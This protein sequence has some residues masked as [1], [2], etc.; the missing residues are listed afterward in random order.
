MKKKSSIDR[1]H[2][3]LKRAPGEFE[4]L[5]ELVAAVIP[6][7]VRYGGD[8]DQETW[9]LEGKVAIWQWDD[10]WHVERCT[11]RGEWAITEGAVR[12]LTHGRCTPPLDFPP[13]RRVEVLRWLNDNPYPEEG[14]REWFARL[15]AV[16]LPEVP[17]VVCDDRG[18]FPRPAVPMN[19][20]LG[21]RVVPIDPREP[22]PKTATWRVVADLRIHRPDETRTVDRYGRRVEPTPEPTPDLVAPVAV[23]VEWA[24]P[25]RRGRRVYTPQDPREG[26][27]M[28]EPT[29]VRGA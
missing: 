27:P 14:A 26:W 1:A 15:Q 28:V 24:L 20:I 4:S 6:E 16:A 7:C 29:E 17:R 5:A 10:L 11:S 8:G 23:L 9:V 18:Y 3:L 21:D 12:S 2:I 19:L 25:G 22:L 13:A